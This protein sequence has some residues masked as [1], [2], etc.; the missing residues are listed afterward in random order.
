MAKKTASLGAEG[1]RSLPNDKP[2][3]YKVLDRRGVNIYTGSAGRG[4]VRARVRDH[5]PGRKDAIPGGTKVQIEQH[6]SIREAQKK[7]A[8]IISRSK[9]KYNRRGK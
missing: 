7:E 2:V 4:N 8:N 6:S 1:I 9:P 3:I 5:L